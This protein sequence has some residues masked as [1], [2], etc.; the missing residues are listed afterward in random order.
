MVKLWMQSLVISLLNV[1]PLFLIGPR[2]LFL[3]GPRLQFLF[4]PSAQFWPQLWHRLWLHNPSGPDP[5]GGQK[6]HCFLKPCALLKPR[7]FQNTVLSGHLN[8]HGRS[9]LLYPVFLL[10]SLCYPSFPHHS[11][12]PDCSCSLVLHIFH[13]FIFSTH[14]PCS[15][16][17]YPGGSLC[18]CPFPFF[19]LLCASFHMSLFWYVLSF[20]TIFSV[21]C[22]LYPSVT[23]TDADLGPESLAFW[24]GL[25]P[26]P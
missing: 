18:P 3:T 16:P 15:S 22:L 24:V 6:T 23:R 20:C 26:G 9:R 8:P 17:L 2:L 1:S 12:C 4:R 25:K 19:L 5:C 14:P 7:A 11:C 10:G 21:F 13:V